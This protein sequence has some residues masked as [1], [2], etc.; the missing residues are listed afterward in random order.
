MSSMDI[1]LADGLRPLFAA[2]AMV[3]DDDDN[4]LRLESYFMSTKFHR[5]Q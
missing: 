3:V 1:R 5:M 2:I 4:F